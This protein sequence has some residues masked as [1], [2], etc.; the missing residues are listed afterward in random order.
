MTHAVV[1]LAIAALAGRARISPRIALA[2]A[3]LAMFPDADVIGFAFGIN[4]ADPWGHRGATHSIALAVLVAGVLA[5]VGRE[6]RSVAA[7]AFLAVAMASHGLLD[8]LTDGGLGVA[9]LWPFHEVRRLAPVT[10]I[11]VSPIG[12]GFFSLRGLETLLSEGLW[13]WLPAGLLVLAARLAG[14][15]RRAPR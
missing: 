14:T 1:P 7:F 9:L 13:V 8:A 12:A 10:P 2:G 15:A 5:V 6:A 3:G 11:H 4:Y